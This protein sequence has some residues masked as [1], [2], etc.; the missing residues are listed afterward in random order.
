MSRSICRRLSIAA[1]TVLLALIAPLP[2][3][4]AHPEA[5]EI[6]RCERDGS[7]VSWQQTPCAPDVEQRVRSIDVE[8]SREAPDAAIALAPSPAVATASGNIRSAPAIQRSPIQVQEKLPRGRRAARQCERPDGSFYFTLSDCGS[9]TVNDGRLITQRIVGIGDP[10][11][12][13]HAVIVSGNTA[14]DPYTDELIPIRGSIDTYV[15]Q[16]TRQVLDKGHVVDRRWACR[17]ARRQADVQRRERDD[18]GFTGRRALDDQVW[19]MCNS[20][21]RLDE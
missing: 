4:A 9:S 16:A 6:Y 18:L 14:V 21:R 12:L 20:T 10:N 8:A 19:D 7:P 3:V 2:A 5:T 15:S 11:R 13:R 1:S 17:E